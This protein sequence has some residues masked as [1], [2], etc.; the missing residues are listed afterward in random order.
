MIG[1]Y[2]F[3]EIRGEVTDFLPIGNYM[4]GTFRYLGETISHYLRRTNPAQ[5]TVYIIR[6][7]V[8]WAK[9][10][11]FKEIST[12]LL[13]IEATLNTYWNTW[14]IGHLAGIFNAYGNY[15][16]LE[17]HKEQ[18]IYHAHSES[19]FGKSQSISMRNFCLQSYG[20][21]MCIHV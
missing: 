9:L 14:N 4:P 8:R 3:I 20:S 19:L 17:A 2:L 10:A 13:Q 1:Q 6:S 16:Q 5:R 7:R 12:D 11:A 18:H 21:A 15:N